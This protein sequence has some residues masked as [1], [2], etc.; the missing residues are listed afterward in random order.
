MP[1]AAYF[2]R[3]AERCHRLA[4]QSTDATLAVLLI[5]M[6]EEYEAKARE[7]GEGGS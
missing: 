4:R 2:L 3:Q 7:I 1:D 5:D 6:A